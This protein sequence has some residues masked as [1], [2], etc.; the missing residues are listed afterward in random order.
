[1]RERPLKFSENG[2][3]QPDTISFIDFGSQRTELGR[4]PHLGSGRPEIHPQ[5]SPGV[6]LGK[7][8]TLSEPRKTS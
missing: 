3:V 1:M 7:L 2:L 5:L 4:V 8:L 6:T